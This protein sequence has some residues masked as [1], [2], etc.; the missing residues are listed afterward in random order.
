MLCVVEYQ[1]D[2]RFVLVK[3]ESYD[4]LRKQKT[5]N[6]EN[7]M[8]TIESTNTNIFK[9][10]KEHPHFPNAENLKKQNS[11]MQD[12]CKIHQ[13]SMIFSQMPSQQLNPK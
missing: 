8:N 6:S 7:S 5:V 10:I 11:I 9:I 2:L 12:G 3:V 1:V 13:S 4:K